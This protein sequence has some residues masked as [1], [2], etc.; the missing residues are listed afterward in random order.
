MLLPS[1]FYK[2]HLAYQLTQA[3]PQ[4]GA[5]VMKPSNHATA[6][7][8]QIDPRAAAPVAAPCDA[9]LLSTADYMLDLHTFDELVGM[10]PLPHTSQLAAPVQWSPDTLAPPPPT[11]ATTSVPVASV[12]T[13]GGLRIRYVAKGRMPT[14]H[15]WR[16]GGFVLQFGTPRDPACSTRIPIFAPVTRMLNRVP[17]KASG[18]SRRTN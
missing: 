13:V 11:P 18:A 7:L 2:K 9:P 12:A 6:R 17:K 5:P 4:P 3:S 8:T 14:H 10:G 16:K 15:P 1:R